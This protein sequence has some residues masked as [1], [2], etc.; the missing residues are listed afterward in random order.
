MVGRRVSAIGVSAVA[1]QL[2]AVWRK[3]RR[4]LPRDIQEA[5]ADLLL[6]CR[7]F[8]VPKEDWSCAVNL[9]EAKVEIKSLAE[10]CRVIAVRDS[11][12]TSEF[13][14][15][16]RSA[17]CARKLQRGRRKVCFDDEVDHCDLPP[18]SPPAIP[19]YPELNNAMLHMD[20]ERKLLQ[21]EADVPPAV[22]QN[23]AGLFCVSCR[24]WLPAETGCDDCCCVCSELAKSATLSCE[25][26][27]VEYDSSVWQLTEND[28]MDSVPCVCVDKGVQVHFSDSDDYSSGGMLVGHRVAEKQCDVPLIFGAMVRTEILHKDESTFRICSQCKVMILWTPFVSG[29][30]DKYLDPGEYFTVAAELVVGDRTWYELPKFGGYVPK[31]SR[32]NIRKQVV[33]AAGR[34]FDEDSD[35]DGI[36][37][38]TAQRNEDLFNAGKT[39]KPLFDVG[40]SVLPTCDFWQ[41]A[42]RKQEI[43]NDFWSTL[44]Q[45]SGGSHSSDC[46][47]Q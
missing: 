5:F 42:Q 44:E 9:K 33:E 14:D 20:L 11:Q 41:E 35:S 8:M 16:C 1:M 19:L 43:S 3:S 32:K 39:E 24:V 23:T 17:V 36:D 13:V 15:Y 6:A 2:G 28:I 31:H 18:C 40:P 46:K 21:C 22:S 47:Q 25:W 26:A 30:S 27:E 10:L 12:V 34:S 38:K 7:S 29:V 37:W 4:D 45:E